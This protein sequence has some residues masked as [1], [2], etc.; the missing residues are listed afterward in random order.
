MANIDSESG[1]A[2]A[3]LG[4]SAARLMQSVTGSEMRIGLN[5]AEFGDISIR[6]TIS[7]HQMVAQISLDHSEL[8]QSISAHAFSMQD[9]LGKEYGLDASIEVNAFASA[10]TGE[11]GDSSHRERA[12]PAAM[13][14]QLRWEVRQRM[15]M[16]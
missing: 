4:L 3:E 2:I 10:H 11:S 14:G 16:V 7:N 6:T 15:E 9:K 12:H 5:S 13:W 8:S 1:K